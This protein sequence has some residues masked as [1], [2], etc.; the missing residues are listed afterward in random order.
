[1]GETNALLSAILERLDVQSAH[2]EQMK[3]DLSQMK[4]QSNVHSELES[5]TFE[6]AEIKED[7]N[8]VKSELKEM[9]EEMALIKQNLAEWKCLWTEEKDESISFE[10]NATI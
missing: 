10:A 8:Q 9:I 6:M 2:L 4:Q 5:L 3:L 1:M 7:L